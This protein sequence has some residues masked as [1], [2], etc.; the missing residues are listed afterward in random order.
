MSFQ[1]FMNHNHSNIVV[2]FCFFAVAFGV[3]RRAAVC[4]L[5]LVAGYSPGFEDP[6]FPHRSSLSRCL[7]LVA[8]DCRVLRQWHCVTAYDHPETREWHNFHVYPARYREIFQTLWS[9][10]FPCFGAG[11][12][13]LQDLCQLWLPFSCCLRTAWSWVSDQ[14]LGHELRRLCPALDHTAELCF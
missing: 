7:L 6:E 9:A 3:H 13:F 10:C 5:A 14:H 2:F 4:P 11:R 1:E 8:W 12:P